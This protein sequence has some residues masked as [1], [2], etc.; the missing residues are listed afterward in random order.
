MLESTTSKFHS[1]HGFGIGGGMVRGMALNA[2]RTVVGG[3]GRSE[4]GPGLQ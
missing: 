2:E 1:S 3:E 4:E